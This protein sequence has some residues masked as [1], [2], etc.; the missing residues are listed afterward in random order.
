MLVLRHSYFFPLPGNAFHNGIFKP[1][2][3]IINGHLE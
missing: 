2:S 3:K 1:N